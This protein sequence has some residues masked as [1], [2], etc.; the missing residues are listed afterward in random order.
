MD[1]G[2]ELMWLTTCECCNAHL[3]AE[4]NLIVNYLYA[5]GRLG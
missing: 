4:Q 1:E 3:S 2:E 5:V